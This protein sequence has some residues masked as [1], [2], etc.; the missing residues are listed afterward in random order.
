MVFKALQASHGFGMSMILWQK[1]E[2]KNSW[3]MA[4]VLYFYCQV[5]SEFD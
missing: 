3:I 4:F 5:I 1:F 2:T